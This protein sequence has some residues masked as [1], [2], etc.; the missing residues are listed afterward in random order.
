MRHAV[1]AQTEGLQSLATACAIAENGGNVIAFKREPAAPSKRAPKPKT[2]AASPRKAA[3]KPI[4]SYGLLRKENPKA[5]FDAAV[6]YLYHSDRALSKAE[7]LTALRSIL[8][9]VGSG[10]LPFVY[11]ENAARVLQDAHAA[12]DIT[13]NVKEEV[14]AAYAARP[15]RKPRTTRKARKG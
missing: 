5:T 7:R 12:G 4:R 6:N 13:P 8:R 15:K 14:E 11:Q 3:A 10:T 9:L 1:L 2:S